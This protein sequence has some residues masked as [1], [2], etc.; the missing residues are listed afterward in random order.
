[1]RSP[2]AESQVMLL[3]PEKGQVTLAGLTS[4]DNGRHVT[5]P[6][7]FSHVPA[8]GPP[9]GGVTRNW[10]LPPRRFLFSIGHS[11][12]TIQR[13]MAEQR[14]LLSTEG[15]AHGKEQGLSG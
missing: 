7:G 10:K 6:R 8:P 1:M 15:E 5:S 2:C 9:A 4:P 14:P 12:V 3:G 13:S 11:L